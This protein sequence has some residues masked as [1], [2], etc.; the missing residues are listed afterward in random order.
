[1]NQLD[2]FSPLTIGDVSLK[3]RVIMAPLTRTRAAEGNV[4]H[5]LN[6]TYYRQ[7]AGAGLIIS[8]ASQVTQAGQGYMHTPG[9]HTDEQVEGWKLVTN[10]VHEEGGKIYLQMW[11][12]G[13]ISHPYFQPNNKPP[14]SSS[15][16]KPDGYART[17]DGK[18]PFVT[19]RALETAEIATVVEQYADGAV[20]AKAA[21][22]DGVEIHGA[23]SYLID[24]F[25]RDSV[26]RRTDR[27]GGSIEN[28]TRFLREV[29]EAV[30]EV[31]GS[32]RV[33]VRLSPGRPNSNMQDSDPAALF[34]YAASILNEYDLSYLHLYE[35]TDEARDITYLI[36]ERFD[37]P[38]ILNGGYDKQRGNAVIA[39]GLADAVAYGKLFIANPD[40]PTRFRLDAPLNEP[41]PKTFYGRDEVGYNDYPS[42]EMAATG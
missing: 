4:P 18:Q 39:E 8:E 32:G 16:V 3:N 12:V 28:R 23:N 29:T 21:G 5:E 37:A 40:L 34:S 19:P 20:R 26:N 2:L 35:T 22:F 25:L 41:N 36:R 24:Q 9:I 33:G 27:Y 31:W 10:A 6:A 1:M 15:A 7:R 42:L 17:P 11:H 38:L 30:V 13:R 14:V